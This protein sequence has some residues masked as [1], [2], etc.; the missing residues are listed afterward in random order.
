MSTV[1][2]DN[3]LGSAARISVGSHGNGYRDVV[4]GA[5][6]QVVTKQAVTPH[7]GPYGCVRHALTPSRRGLMIHYGG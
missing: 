7:R 5:A 3:E 6:W 4:Q 1:V 2:V